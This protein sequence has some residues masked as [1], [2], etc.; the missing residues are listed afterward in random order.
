MQETGV[1]RG[2]MNDGEDPESL[3]SVLFIWVDVELLR[4][5]E[6]PVEGNN[7]DFAPGADPVRQASWNILPE[8]SAFVLGKK[9]KPQ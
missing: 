2:G 9:E 6:L 3:P 8:S 5:G 1:G 4:W 7:S